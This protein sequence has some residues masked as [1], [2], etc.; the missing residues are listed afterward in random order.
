MEVVVQIHKACVYKVF[1]T[2]CDNQNDKE[3]RMYCPC[4]HEYVDAVDGSKTYSAGN[5]QA[6]AVR[7]GHM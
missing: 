4:M 1:V 7:T 6:L 5:E 2:V 3:T